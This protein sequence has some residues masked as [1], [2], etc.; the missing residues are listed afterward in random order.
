MAYT[1]PLRSD[2]THYDM[3]LTLDGVAYTFE[4]RWNTRAGAWFMDIQTDE[5]EHIVSS[6]KVVIDL[7]L[8]ARSRDARKP[9]GALF[10]VDTSGKGLDPGVS[11]LGER[12]QLVYFTKAELPV[13]V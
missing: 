11:D 12:V 3:Q 2:L 6:I 13:E 4:F 7:P 10:A 9:A 1:L 8:G 5:G